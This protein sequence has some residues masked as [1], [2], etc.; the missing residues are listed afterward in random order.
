MRPFV[1]A[2]PYV[3]AERFM[4]MSYGSLGGVWLAKSTGQVLPFWCGGTSLLGAQRRHQNKRASIH[5]GKAHV[6]APKVVT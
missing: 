1:L 4:V 3:F 2:E 6:C 5:L